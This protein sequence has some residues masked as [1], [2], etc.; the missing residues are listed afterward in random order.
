MS[1]ARCS[2]AAGAE[3]HVA[4]IGGTLMPMPRAVSQGFMLKTLLRMMDRNPSSAPGFA[5][6]PVTTVVALAMG[7]LALAWLAPAAQAARMDSLPPSRTAVGDSVPPYDSDAFNN[8]PASVASFDY[9]L[10]TGNCLPKI[11]Q[12]SSGD[13]A[14]A[15][16]TIT[17][18]TSCSADSQVE[19]GPTSSYGF[20]S[21]LDV[22]L[23]TT[24]AVTLFNLLPDT[25]YY[26]RVVS[27]TVTG[28]KVISDDF[29][30]RTL[31]A[32]PIPTVYASA[33]PRL[34][35]TLT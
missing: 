31:L 35:D 7:L 34:Q 23:S 28:Q 3:A 9:S 12:V 27:K 14:S 6:L 26:Y 18:M 25:V 21:S 8:A 2:L 19:Y 20:M 29:V 16:A 15:S 4:R 13:P 32:P 30:V 22:T 11:A 33:Y 1:N 10:R 17:W 24:H 5:G